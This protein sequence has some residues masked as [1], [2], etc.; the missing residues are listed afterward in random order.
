M[1]IAAQTEPGYA[2]D[3]AW[4]QAGRR[5]RL[6]EE[7]LDPT[8]ERRLDAV[9]VGRGWRCLE[10]GAGGGSVARSLCERVG[11]RGRVVAVDL[12]TR[13]LEEDAPANLEVHERDIV[14]EGLPGGGYDLVHTRMLLVH[15]PERE[16]VLAELIA[17]LAPGGWLVLEEAD[18]YPLTTAGSSLYVEA[19]RTV[20]DALAEA[21]M[22]AG[23]GRELPGLL[24]RA[25]LDDVAAEA[26]AP[27]FRGASTWA[28]LFSLSWEQA[29]PLMRSGAN[30]GGLLDAALAEMADP[31]RWF[32][33]LAIVA[34]CGRRP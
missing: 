24:T 7:A 19:W 22:A 4:A 1:S 3:N 34:A 32:P 26:E 18:H 17:A 28:Q 6:L 33:C 27:Y 14:A 23:W 16:R 10:V 13:F 9:G 29:R 30:P 21:G 31:R 5:L 8:T 11:P 15:L 20:L 25:G 12:D 2:F